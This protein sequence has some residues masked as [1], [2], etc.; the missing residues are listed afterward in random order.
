MVVGNG[1]G[2]SGRRA[3]RPARRATEGERR[4]R[5]GLRRRWSET[6]DRGDGAPAVGTGARRPDPDRVREEERG[7]TGSWGKGGATGLGFRVGGL[8]GKGGCGSG[9]AHSGSRGQRGHWPGRG[10]VGHEAP[11]VF[12][13]LFSYM[14]FISFLFYF[15]PPF[16]LF[17]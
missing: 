14:Y 1:I 8:V 10:L 13:F 12:L 17:L 9:P 15:V 7:E 11:F 4:R 2:R 3:R 5:R 16:I 6:G